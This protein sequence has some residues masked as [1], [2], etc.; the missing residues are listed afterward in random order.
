MSI[1]E[2]DCE[3]PQS[4]GLLSE[5]ESTSANARDRANNVNRRLATVRD[6]IFGT[7]PEV[8][9]GK[10]PKGHEDSCKSRINMNFDGLH[11]ELAA[12]ENILT[13]FEDSL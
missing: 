7:K 5:I 6:R 13:V 4:Q 8:E 3:A 9:S 12:M 11:H 2:A 10:E 1:A